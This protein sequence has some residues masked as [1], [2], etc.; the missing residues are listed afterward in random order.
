M[1]L[2]VHVNQRSAATIVVSGTDD[3]SGPG[4]HRY[5]R[6]SACREGSQGRSNGQGENLADGAPVWFGAARSGT[7][8][9]AV[10]VTPW[11]AVGRRSRRK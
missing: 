10:P 9:R 6:I 7:G 3:G 4:M 1:T 2:V 11:R 5:E 8:C